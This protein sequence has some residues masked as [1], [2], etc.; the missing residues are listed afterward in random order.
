[1]RTWLRV[2]LEARATACC[3]RRGSRAS[4][5]AAPASLTALV[6]EYSFDFTRTAVGAMPKSE[7]ICV[8]FLDQLA[9]LEECAQVD[10][11]PGTES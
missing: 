7:Q 2:L 5:C 4:S 1:M 10:D 11:L 8:N 9:L 6:F 3:L